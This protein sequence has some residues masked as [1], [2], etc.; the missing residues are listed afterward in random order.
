MKLN[1]LLLVLFLSTSLGA[2]TSIVDF[3]DDGAGL[4]DCIPTAEWI[5]DPNVPIVTELAN[6][7]S[8]TINNTPNCVQYIET[9]GSVPGNSLQ[10]AFNGTTARTGHN[11][12]ANKFVKFMVYS[13]NQTNF[14]VLLEL[15]TGSTPNFSM[16]K[17]ISTT[18]NTW[19]E[20]EF[21]FTGNDP[22]ATINNSTGWN[23][24]IRIHFNNGT[25]GQGDVYYV[26]EYYIT[27][28][29]TV[30]PLGILYT[31]NPIF[32]DYDVIGGLLKELTIDLSTSGS[33]AN[34]TI[35]ADNEILVDNIDLPFAGTHSH[36][37]IV[38]FPQ[39]GIV[40]LKFVATGNDLIVNSYSFSNYS[41]N[42]FPDFGNVTGSVG[43]VD[44]ESL[45]YGG[46]T[47]ADIDNNGT[48]DLVLNNH[49][50][51]PSKLYW[52]N[53]NTFTKYN[54]DLSLFTLMDLHGS[55]A[56]DYDN[57]GDLDLV[58]SLGG[59]N[60][61]NPT[62]PLF[63]CNNNGTLDTCATS[64]GITS[65]ARGR[66]PRWADLDLDGDLDLILVNAAGINGNNGAQ[67]VFYENLGDGTFQPK[68]VV[69]LENAGG[70]KL[71]VTDLDGDCIDDIVMFSPVSLWKGNGDFTF[72]NISSW[73]PG[74]VNGAYGVLAAADID[75]DNDGDLDLYFS[76]GEYYF[77]VA[78]NNSADFFPLTSKL[79]MRV[80]G[81]TGTL[82]FTVNAGGDISISKYSHLK[83][84]GYT[85]GFPLY[86]GSGAT[87]HTMADY[88]DTF[89]I[90]QAAAAG[91][92]SSR[93]QNGLYIGYVGN[94]LWEMEVVRNANIY[95]HI[96]FSF[97]DV[98]GFTPTGWTPNNRNIQDIL[99]ENNN[100][101]FT[102]V[103]TQWNI[104]IGGNHW[105][106]TKGDFN[107]DSF[108]DLYVYRFGYL[109]NRRS[110]YLLLNTGQGYFDVTNAH[111]ADN[112]G[113]VDHGDMGQ[114]F[115]YDLDGNVDIFNGDDEFGLWHLYQNSG[116]N[117]NNYVIVDVGYSPTSNV[118]A[119]SAVVTIMTPSGTYTK[120][121]GSA[122]E[123]HSQSLLNLVHFGIGTDNII[124]SVKVKWRNGETVCS[125]NE[126][127]NQIIESTL[128]LPIELLDFR[129]F[130]VD[131]GI[132]LIWKTATELNNEKF[133]ILRSVDGR[134]FQKIGETPGKGT[135]SKIQ[136]YSF[137]DRTPNKGLNYYQLKQIDFDGQFSLSNII[138][139]NYQDDDKLVGQF[140][141]NPSLEG[142]V[143]LNFQ[144]ISDEAMI[145]T[146]F[147]IS[148]KFVMQ[149][150]MSVSAG[151]NLMTF[152]FSK[153]E[154]GSYLV[155]LGDSATAVYRKLILE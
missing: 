110:D 36:K 115:D 20:V 79:D 104:P 108:E 65:S 81:S 123:A 43:I 155:K 7:N 19:T 136:N 140:F 125:A 137:I 52:N 58:I 112:E 138:S 146:V 71:L 151:D 33:Y 57:D 120:R 2:Q 73:L 39:S 40:E 35:Y 38:K 16:S 34:F 3:E 86:L 113:S 11:L 149:R 106:V 80:S 59:G 72:T 102:D 97:D 131:E 37:I 124:D 153:L 50:D 119:I 69:G 14:D 54:P 6:P 122:G 4:P 9:V 26:D 96:E 98:S 101:S 83:R 24:N 150:T 133:E 60:G 99:L 129:G 23:S 76:R 77:T 22:A 68:A 32:L 88:D 90:T 18:L 15:G 1:L 42:D 145:V 82:P 27:P 121:V 111:G 44:D 49:N 114:A 154:R 17:N 135:T 74:G 92:P 139:I 118:D 127:V 67:H 53:G 46:P 55:A 89:A 56:G 128:M 132:E 147:D 134:N 91:W 51:S 28:T 103:S 10:L 85:G 142:I 87:S 41:N 95:W 143:Y 126:A 116:S 30:G 63:Y 21:D 93:T 130:E 148:G 78:E 5:N 62:P 29:S 84:S 31:T 47:I 100:G 48:Y 144:A 141:P 105:G 117:S 61:T 107:N 8:T 70:E 64:V 75:I 109:K 13:E 25:A 45:K 66:S 94:G 152:D 12:V